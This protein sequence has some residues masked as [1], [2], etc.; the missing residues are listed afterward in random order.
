ML[1]PQDLCDQLFAEQEKILEY[2]SV[3]SNLKVSA[4]VDNTNKNVQASTIALLL[5]DYLAQIQ[6]QH[7]SDDSNLILRFDGLDMRNKACTIFEML[8]RGQVTDL[9][10]PLVVRFLSSTAGQELSLQD[11]ILMLLV[12]RSL[13]NLQI[14]GSKELVQAILDRILLSD[15]SLSQ[16]SWF[17]LV[18]IELI[19]DHEITKHAL[20]NF[21]ERPVQHSFDML[22]HLLERHTILKATWQQPDVLK[23]LIA[24]TNFA[25]SILKKSESQ[26][27]NLIR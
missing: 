1:I 24:D 9:R 7:V 2:L 21:C 17:I 22:A 15:G 14:V 23:S 6:G 13:Q 19:F 18:A 25:L 20:E 4:S 10:N 5:R 16:N 27:V 8:R 3:T 12:T 26:S 11:A